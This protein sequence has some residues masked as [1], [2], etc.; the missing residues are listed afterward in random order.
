MPEHHE[1]SDLLRE[2]KE[3]GGRSYTAL[4]ARTGLSRSSVHRYCRGLTVPGSFGTVERIARVCGAAPEELDRLYQAW[5]RAVASAEAGT[6]VETETHGGSGSGHG[7][8]GRPTAR[9]TGTGTA[10]ATDADTGTGTGTGTPTPQPAFPSPLLDHGFRAARPPVLPH[11]PVRVSLR[12]FLVIALLAAASLAAAAGFDR[13]PKSGAGKGVAATNGTAATGAATGGTA[14]DGTAKDGTA[15]GDTSRQRIVGPQ[16]SMAPQPLKRE[17]F[18]MTMNTDTGDMPD[19]RVGGVRLW[20]GET[21][22]GQVEPARGRFDWTILERMVRAAERADLPV[23]FT[24][25]GTPGWAAPD[26]TRTLY[27]D[28]TRATPPDDLADWDRFVEALATRYRGRIESYE[29]WDNTSTA[30]HF[31]GSVGE[32]AEMVRRASRIIRRVDPEAVVACPSFSRLWER[33]GRSKLRQFA[34]TGAYEHCDAAAVKLH[35]RRADGPPEEIIELATRVQGIL[36]EEDVGPPLW[37]TGP[38]KDIATTGPID[39][40]RAEDYAVRFYLA[41]LYSRK[42]KLERMYFYSWGST[43]VPLVVQPVGGAPTEAG[44]RVGRL[45]EWLDGAR[46]TS[47]GRG[48]SVGL[49]E[50]AYECRFR[51]GPEP[52]RAWAAIRWTRNGRAARALEPGAHLLRRMDG[53]GESVRPGDRPGF[54]ES[55]VMVLYG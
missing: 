21:R 45:Q 50:N 7:P 33:Q 17:F 54:G 25:G 52:A 32:L 27:G 9:G 37:N 2:L 43:G 12:T 19:F 39:A 4:A 28:D 47:C 14:K 11:T 30:T 53:G 42:A 26:G 16:W 23:L 22:W 35:P 10:P 18:G 6:G 5:A 15:T 34:R 3:R 1:L 36:Y 29:L 46:I 13:L 44:V 49:P 31:A 51:L 48:T 40:R 38:G 8:G 24:F 55:P 41:G 20:D